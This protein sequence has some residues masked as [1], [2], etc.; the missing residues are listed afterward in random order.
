MTENMETYSVVAAP[1]FMTRRVRCNNRSTKTM[2]SRI[3]EAQK[4][5]K[6]TFKLPCFGELFVS[7]FKMRGI[8]SK[9]A[10]TAASLAHVTNYYRE[11]CPRCFI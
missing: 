3:I 5:K 4:E 10:R 6:N 8:M 2:M 1:C 11:T 9:C 7:I